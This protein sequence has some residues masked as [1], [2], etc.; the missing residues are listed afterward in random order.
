[1]KN[2]GKMVQS[3]SD[4]VPYQGFVA[5]G[6]KPE[7][8]V[9]KNLDI[10]ADYRVKADGTIEVSGNPEYGPNPHRTYRIAVE[11]G[12]DQRITDNL[13]Q[14]LSSH[15]Q[16]KDASMRPSLTADEGLVS[17]TIRN[18]YAPPVQPESPIPP[19]ETQPTD[20]YDP[21]DCSPGPGSPDCSPEDD[22]SPEDEP[23]PA[24]VE[25]MSGGERLR[26]ATKVNSYENG[27]ANALGAY[28]TNY[29]GWFS[30]FLDDEMLA[31]LGNPPD[32][33][34]L[35]RVLA[36]AKHKGKFMQK[37]GA[38]VNGLK[39]EGATLSAERMEAFFNKLT[40]NETFAAGFGEFM[41]RQ[42]KGQNASG[43]DLRQYFDSAM[44]DTVASS[45]LVEAARTVGVRLSQMTD[46]Q[47][48]EVALAVRT[49]HKPTPEE[50]TQNANFVNT[51][52]ERFRQAR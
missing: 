15:I 43:D 30:S 18:Q 31:E 25:Q 13:V 23:P 16:Q 2:D 36:N 29:Y 9:S 14:Y 24:P 40:T 26:E 41:D 33:K 28:E 3:P 46:A 38:A 42:Q 45:Q 44:Q 8:I 4:Q 21:G 39:D 11:P 34:K 10:P 5:P 27:T 6:E 32:M 19:D 20:D 37:A 49:G 7:I 47:A 1:M 12:A 50:L 48:G 51:I 22:Y 35:A 17:S 52:G